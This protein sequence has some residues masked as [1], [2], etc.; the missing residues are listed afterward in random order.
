MKLLL[1][2]VKN[3]LSKIW[4]AKILVKIRNNDFYKTFKEELIAVPLMLIIFYLINGWL[5]SM[6][7]QGAFFDF[8]SQLETIISKILLFSISLWVAHLAL[9]ISFPKIYK[10][11]HETIYSNFNSIS[12]EKKLDYTVKF[13][14]VFIL[15]SA[16][17][18]SASAQTKTYDE[19][20]AMK[21]RTELIDSIN[22][23]LYVRETSENRG[24]MID[25]YLKTV[26]SKL[27]NPWCGAFVGSNLTWQ[28]VKNPNSAWSPDY[29]KTTDIIWTSKN[30]NKVELLP[31]DVV[32]YYYP[33]I[34][35]IGH[36]GFLE[37]VDKS[38]Y[39]ITVE[40]NTNG[41]GLREGDGVY[42]KKREPNKIH[43]ISRYIKITPIK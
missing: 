3:I 15:A 27:G 7:P 16:L 42:K 22:K 31:G 19:K 24:P 18:F 34:R 36:T 12:E 28:N 14:L 17:V 4:N 5:I 29:A 2:K 41:A 9:I 23:Q 38:G 39:F 6:F 35:R 11:L 13:I 26:K 25:I 30:K 20:E 40:G 32:T 8:Y 33:E 37:K 1:L 43:A 10:Y 21:I